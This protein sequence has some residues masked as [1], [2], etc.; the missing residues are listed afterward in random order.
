[1]WG[2][3][4]DIFH[5]PGNV[6]E[7]WQNH[8]KGKAAG[9]GP[10]GSVLDVHKRLKPEAYLTK[11]A[12]TPV[13]I[14]EE[15]VIFRD[16]EILIPVKNRFDHTNMNELTLVCRR[17][18][19][20]G[21]KGI[22][23]TDRQQENAYQS[24][25]PRKEVVFCGQVKE[26]IPPHGSGV[27]Q[28]D[29]AVAGEG[30]TLSLEF[31]KGDELIDEYRIEAGSRFC[32]QEYPVSS[33]KCK[34][35]SWREP[36]AAEFTE[37][38]KE[39][40]V[41]AGASRFC[42]D[43]DTA[44]M[45]MAQYQGK[46]LLC[47]GPHLV[48]TGAVLGEWRKTGPGV[49]AIQRG[50]QVLVTLTGQYSNGY[51]VWYTI[52]VGGDGKFITSYQIK[53]G[54][55]DRTVKEFGVG[56]DLMPGA[57]RISWLRRGQYS[58]YPEDHIGRN[59]GIAWR[60]NEKAAAC[61][62]GTAPEWSWKED[63]WDDF[64]YGR[65]EKENGLVTKDFKAL[66]ENIRYFKVHFQDGEEYVEAEDSK[67]GTAARVSVSVDE[68]GEERTALLLVKRWIYPDLGWGNEEKRR[69]CV[70]AGAY[71]SVRMKFGACP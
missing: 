18:G 37:S 40:V 71:G 60:R 23:E 38:E 45:T 66:R 17:Q 50:S 14:E 55:T 4:D 54:G 21:E 32:R 47:G 26:N 44:L 49:R 64:L 59:R 53:G 6:K 48:L 51:A 8:S 42:F 12:Y 70:G 67:D 30:E 9:Y 15:A 11:K 10:W 58:C 33:H 68:N 24:S 25:K 39:L 20:A 41:T 7:K 46:T 34:A 65:D 3:I 61:G 16:G 63:M 31:Y 56:Y 2:G 27:L 5:L 29:Y 57:E 1:M 35:E 19:D 36:A 22:C 52:T 43:K 62:Y 28:L 13:R 69:F